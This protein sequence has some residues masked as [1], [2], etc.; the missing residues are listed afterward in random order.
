GKVRVG[1]ENSLYNADGSLAL[2]NSE[3]VREIRGLVQAK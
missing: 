2:S 3:R 1:F